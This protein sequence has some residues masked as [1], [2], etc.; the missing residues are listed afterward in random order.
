MDERAFKELLRGVKEL[1][2]LRRG[3]P[4]KGVKITEVTMDEDARA[5]RELTKL[6]QAEFAELVA[7]PVKTLQNWEQNRTKPTGPARALLRAI[8]NDPRAVLRALHG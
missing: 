3:E 2:K 7:V 8:A 4:V 5:V 1:G 6:S